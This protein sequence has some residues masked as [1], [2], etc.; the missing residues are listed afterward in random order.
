MESGK[1]FSLRYLS[2]IRAES[3]MYCSVSFWHRANKLTKPKVRH[4]RK[5]AIANSIL[6]ESMGEQTIA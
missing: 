5:A 1:I 2:P 6:F 4:D 3:G